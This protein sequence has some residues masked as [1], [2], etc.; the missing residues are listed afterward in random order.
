MTTY[1]EIGNFTFG[2]LLS[3]KRLFE[4]FIEHLFVS[5]LFINGKISS[6]DKTEFVDE[7]LK[8]LLQKCITRQ[9]S[10]PKIGAFNHSK[11]IVAIVVISVYTNIEQIDKG[12]KFRELG[13]YTLLVTSLIT[14]IRPMRVNLY[15][16]KIILFVT[17]YV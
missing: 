1:N 16:R 2:M 17:K 13:F 9:I 11:V 7:E 4:N 3:I 5:N 15:T 10:A 8:S 14:L 12:F 6:I